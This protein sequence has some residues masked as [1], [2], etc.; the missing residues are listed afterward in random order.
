VTEGAPGVTEAFLDNA[1][2]KEPWEA[3]VFAMAVML[4]ERGL[5]SWPEWTLALSCE[6]QRAKSA[7]HPDLGG[8]YYQHWLNALETLVARAA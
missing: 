8:T 6:I 4:H 2:F 3:R 7:G 5:F 1:V